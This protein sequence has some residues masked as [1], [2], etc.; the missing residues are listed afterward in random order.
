MKKLSQSSDVSHL[1]KDFINSIV[2]VNDFKLNLKEGEL[3]V[4][5][6][7]GADT[8]VNYHIQLF[9]IAYSFFRKEDTE[10]E[11]SV[12]DASLDRF[13]DCEE[14][15]IMHSNAMRNFWV[16]SFHSGIHHLIV[17]FKELKITIIANDKSNV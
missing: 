4:L 12:I 5:C 17:G 15:S 14:V 3:N 13:N 6:I 9:N 8:E 2:L 16:L 7:E 10:S 11:F 1:S